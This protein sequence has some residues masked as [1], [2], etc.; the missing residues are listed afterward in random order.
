MV[1]SPFSYNFN[2]P[3]ILSEAGSIGASSSPYWWLNS[4]GQF[5]LV[6]GIGMTLQGDTPLGSV[7]QKMYSSSNPRDTDNGLHPQNLFRFVTRSKWLNEDQQVDFKIT[8]YHLSNSPERYNPNGVLLFNRYVDGNNLYYAGM[9]VD[10]NVVIKKKVNGVYYTLA[11]KKFFPGVY[12]R[13]SSPNLLPTNVWMSIR[14]RVVTNTDGTVTLT[15]SVDPTH[16]RTWVKALEVIDDGKTFGPAI[17]SSGYGGIRTD[18]MDAYFND[19]KI[20]E[21]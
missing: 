16:S 13:T 18:F 17:K 3:G 5:N 15:L 1:G 2:V 12:N 8:R 9:R 19:Y 21:L 10:G 11:E 14:S 20:T 4:G 7:W 6:N